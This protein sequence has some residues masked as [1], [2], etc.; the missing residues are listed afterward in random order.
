MYREYTFL[1]AGALRV[2]TAREL[3]V[4]SGSFTSHS[5]SV[6]RHR[7]LRGHASHERYTVSN[8]E[9]QETNLHKPI[10]LAMGIKPGA[11]A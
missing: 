11:A 1:D 2:V 10:Q 8:V 4:F 7:Q 3:V 9:G 5:M 6:K